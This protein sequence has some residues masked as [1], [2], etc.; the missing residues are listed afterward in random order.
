GAPS[1]AP[2]PAAHQKPTAERSQLAEGRP[3]AGPP[4]C[5][6]VVIDRQVGE[7]MQNRAF[8]HVGGRECLPVLTGELRHAAASQHLH[9]LTGPDADAADRIRC[10]PPGGVSGAGG[11]LTLTSGQGVSWVDD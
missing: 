1:A 9:S 3:R 8:C 11:R 4:L 5:T 7:D 10:R 6:L 2:Y